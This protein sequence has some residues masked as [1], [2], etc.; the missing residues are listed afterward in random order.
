MG[1]AVWLYFLTRELVRQPLQLAGRLGIVGLAALV[2][3]ALTFMLPAYRSSFT[4]AVEQSAFDVDLA[5]C[6]CTAEDVARLRSLPGVERA[7][8]V[9]GI[10]GLAVSSSSAQAGAWAWAIDS[11]EDAD[12]LPVSPGYLIDGRYDLGTP[13]QPRVVVDRELARLLGVAA[14]DRIQARFP[15]AVVDLTVAGIT[16]PAARFR[17][18]AL[19]LLRQV[20]TPLIPADSDLVTA[21]YTEVLISGSVSTD[22]VAAL[23]PIGTTAVYTKNE[24]IAAQ[25]AQIE[26]SL[27]VIEVVSLLAGV[28]LVAVLSFAGWQ[29]VDRRRDLLSLL[30]HMGS[31]WSSGLTA[32]LVIEGLPT[33][34]ASA[35]ATAI[36]LLVVV[37]GY[38]SGVGAFVSLP[39]IALASAAVAVMALLLHAVSYALGYTRFASR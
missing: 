12:L 32:T 18:P 24:Q 33:A 13:V 27:P 10:G 9:L 28:G 30:P 2:L 36:G 22:V 19:V 31:P 15:T 39:S 3:A 8:P 34:L 1:V 5:A 21:P 26:L 35:A 38:F 14:G 17:G 11:A 16:G 37:N 6:E 23:F 20:V 7:L 29:A 4:A 25:E